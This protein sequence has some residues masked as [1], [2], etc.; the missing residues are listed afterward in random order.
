MF[1][2]TGRHHGILYHCVKYQ[3][4]KKPIQIKQ[5]RLLR[6]SE[7][8]SINRFSHTMLIEFQLCEVVYS[9]L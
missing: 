1:E 2:A 7:A 8:M 5:F 3:W 4:Q 9:S 6:K